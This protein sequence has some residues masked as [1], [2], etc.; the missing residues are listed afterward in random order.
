MFLLEA[1]VVDS[2]QNC[3][4]AYLRGDN[5]DRHWNYEACALGA[6]PMVVQL[7]FDK[8]CDLYIPKPRAVFVPAPPVIFG[9]DMNL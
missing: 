6:Y 5:P 9:E 7:P 1:V 3:G 8:R 2:C 4:H